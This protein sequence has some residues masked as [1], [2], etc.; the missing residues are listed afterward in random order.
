MKW[1]IAGN[2]ENRSI[3]V[4]KEIDA[5]LKV[6]YARERPTGGK[7]HSQARRDVKACLA[8]TVPLQVLF[9]PADVKFAT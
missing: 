1:A 9:F 3:P 6:I 5:Y 4:A 7:L 8:S 2:N